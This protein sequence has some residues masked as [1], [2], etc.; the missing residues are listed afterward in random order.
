MA[1]TVI[2]CSRWD[3]SMVNKWVKFIDG[4]PSHSYVRNC[5]GFLSRVDPLTSVWLYSTGGVRGR[6][7]VIL[8]KKRHVFIIVNHKAHQNQNKN[9]AND[10]FAHLWQVVNCANVTVRMW[11]NSKSLSPFLFTKKKNSFQICSFL[12]K[13]HC[14]LKFCGL[15]KCLSTRNVKFVQSWFGCLNTLC[16]PGKY[17]I[18]DPSF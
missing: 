7:S 14:S 3:V 17:C 13:V 18:K 10:C 15:T 1:C 2:G 8:W 4:S 9:Y 11:T 16:K 12:V 5:H 6:L